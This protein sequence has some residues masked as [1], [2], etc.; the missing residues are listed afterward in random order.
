MKRSILIL[1][2]SAFLAIPASAHHAWAAF[3]DVNGDV[4]FEGVISDIQWV[5]PHV[6]VK[7][8]ENA[9]SANEKEWWTLSNSVAA[10]TRMGITQEVLAVG[11]Q[12]RVAGYP[13]RSSTDGVF[14]N[15]LLLP[16]GEEVVFLRT[17]EPR[18]PEADRIGNTD[19]AHGRVHEEDF[20]KRPTT[21]FSVWNTIYGAEGSHQALKY[22]R[23]PEGFSI[24]Y[25]EARGTGGCVS[26]DVWEEMGAPY[27][28]EIIDNGNGTVTIHA[29][30]FDTIRTVHMDIE[31]ND[32]GTVKNN[33]GYSTGYMEDGKL[34]VKTTFAGSNSPI[35][36][37][38]T[39]WLS[40]DHNR[41]L[42]SNKLS[43][44]QT[45]KLF[46]GERWWE[47]QPNSFIQPYECTDVGITG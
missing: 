27:P 3:F 14:M 8:I 26:K 6:S 16:S 44:P 4:E 34:F 42:Y 18:W 31:H 21:I 1:G 22:P 38:E 37:E 40:E 20:S 45:G 36:F 47:Y 29:E 2:L 24:N 30:E 39:F 11:T 46:E 13:S 12:V 7:F 28:M 23:G 33:L 10:L 41:L 25:A 32:P 9:G 15:H 35:V 19:I 17:A 5:N 43:N